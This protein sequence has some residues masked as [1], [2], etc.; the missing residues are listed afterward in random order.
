MSC[1]S[2]RSVTDL[3]DSASCPLLDLSDSETVGEPLT[4][5]SYVLANAWLSVDIR[6]E[7]PLGM[8]NSS[9][10]RRIPILA[11]SAEVLWSKVVEVDGILIHPVLTT[12][13][14]RRSIKTKDPP[15]IGSSSKNIP[16]CLS[17]KPLAGCVRIH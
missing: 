17:S 2:P 9:S 12:S 1:S 3:K 7:H 15:P 16:C 8:F 13:L 11:V 4:R 6:T 5:L 10:E 14:P